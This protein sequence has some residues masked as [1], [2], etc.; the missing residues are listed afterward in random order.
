MSLRAAIDKSGSVAAIAVEIIATDGNCQIFLLTFLWV[1]YQGCKTCYIETVDRHWYL[2][3]MDQR[4]MFHQECL[5]MK[6]LSSSFWSCCL[7]L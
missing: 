6:I 2:H 3:L 4:A 5:M 7:K 1:I